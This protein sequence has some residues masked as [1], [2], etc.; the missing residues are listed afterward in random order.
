MKNVLT[1]DI[2]FCFQ[3]MY[4]GKNPHQ[5]LRF[6]KLYMFNIMLVACKKAI[7]KNGTLRVMYVLSVPHAAFH[8]F[9]YI[10]FH[11]YLYLFYFLF[12]FAQFT[13]VNK[14]K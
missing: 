12:L 3:V 13:L 1:C 5:L 7:K 11:L 10:L 14:K 4:L 8:F 6:P 9:L 2:E